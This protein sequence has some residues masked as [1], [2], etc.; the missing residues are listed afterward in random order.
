MMTCGGVGAIWYVK[1]SHK[2]RLQDIVGALGTP[3]GFWKNNP[4]YTNGGNT[5]HVQYA[6]LCAPNC[7]VDP[8]TSVTR[9]ATNG[10]FDSV[11]PSKVEMILTF[12]GDIRGEPGD[13][14]LILNGTC[15]DLHKPGTRCTLELDV[16]LK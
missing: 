8:V 12:G 5:L 3:E 13:H 2:N 9:W 16:S 11:S 4:E 15:T 10:G 7:D 14:V 1:N 6:T